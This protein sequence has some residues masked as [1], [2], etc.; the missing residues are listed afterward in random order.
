MLK[1]K[2]PIDALVDFLNLFLAENCR[3][4]QILANEF[5]LNPMS[6]IE[7]EIAVSIRFVTQPT[8]RADQFSLNGL[9]LT[10][11]WNQLIPETLEFGAPVLI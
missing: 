7:I 9:G 11:G 6:P 5:A 4:L 8:D 1:V 2:D 10:R 3:V